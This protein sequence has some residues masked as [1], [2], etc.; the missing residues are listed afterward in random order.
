LNFSGGADSSALRLLCPELLPVSVDFTGTDN[1]WE[2]AERIRFAQENSA[3]VK[4]NAHEFLFPHYPI[5]YYN[6]GSLLAADSEGIRFAVDG[7]VMTDTVR[8]FEFLEGVHPSA[9][10]LPDEVYGVKTLYPLVGMTRAGTQKIVSR[11]S[12]DAASVIYAG[13]GCGENNRRVLMALLDEA[14][15]GNGGVGTADCADAMPYGANRLLDFY[16][17][18]LVNRLG[19]ERASLYV[20]EIP[21]EAV[22]LAKSLSMN[23]YEKYDRRALA[24]LPADFA[25]YFA[26]RLEACGVEFYTEADYEEKA[27]VVEMLSIVVN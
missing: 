23:F 1:P 16:A 12:A 9:L 25:E 26:G 2:A 24:G 21:R 6:L 14:T 19:E 27:A 3:V 5:G 10:D 15:G 11:L 13:V 7:R 22:E 17:L 4:T 8:T 18:Y 20:K